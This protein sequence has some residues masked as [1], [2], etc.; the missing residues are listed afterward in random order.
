MTDVTGTISGRVTDAATGQ[1]IRGAIVSVRGGAIA[2]GAETD[3]RGAY[4]VPNLPVARYAVEA[5]MLGY[6]SGSADVAMRIGQ[7]A[8][9]DFKLQPKG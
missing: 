5:V 2:M 1:G 7:P 6:T 4:R 3:G 9:C 8:I